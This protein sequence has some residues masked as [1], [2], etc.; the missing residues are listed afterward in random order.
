M[1]SVIK[2]SIAPVRSLAL[3]HPAEIDLTEVGVV[4]D[5]R[6]YLIDEAD[7]LIDRIIAGELVQV[8]ATTDPGATRLAM[9]FPDGTVLDDQVALGDHVRTPIHDRWGEGRIVLGPWAEALEPFAGRPIRIVRC[10]RP[11]GTRVGN[12]TSLVGDGSLVEIARRAGVPAIDAR[13]FRMLIE[14]DGLAAH[15]EDTW[16]GRRVRV[17]GAVLSIT[18]PDARCA[19]TTQDPDTGRRDLDTLRAIIGYRGLRDGKY[20]DFGILGDVVEPGRVRIGD[21]I[22]VLDPG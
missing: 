13:R 4:E 19:I 16:I 5:R 18:K 7:R 1:P 20:A 17:G 12:P 15:E 14:M 22:D 10:D 21:E 11:G 6:F 9:T 2:F 3:Q 8:A